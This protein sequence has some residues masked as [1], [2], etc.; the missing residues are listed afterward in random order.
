MKAPIQVDYCFLN[1]AIKILVDKEKQQ[2][3]KKHTPV[4][5]STHLNDLLHI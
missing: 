5:K 4:P 1:C 3:Q 2:Q